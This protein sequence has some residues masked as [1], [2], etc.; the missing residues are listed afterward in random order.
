MGNV[1]RSIVNNLFGL[2]IKDPTCDFKLF[3][4]EVID[5]VRIESNSGFVC[6][7]MM[8]KIQDKGYKIVEVGVHHFPRLFGRSQSFKLKRVILMIKDLCIQWVKYLKNG[9]L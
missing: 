9:K 5:S 7:E 2:K 6:V 3:K 4:K 8:K 1:Y